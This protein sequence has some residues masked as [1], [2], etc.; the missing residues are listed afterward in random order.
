MNICRQKTISSKNFI[1]NSSRISKYEDY[2]NFRVVILGAEEGHFG[3]VTIKKSSLNASVE[4]AFC[5][6]FSNPEQSNVRLRL[7]QG[8]PTLTVQR[9]AWASARGLRPDGCSGLLMAL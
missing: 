6:L 2:Q 4:G 7:R 3:P 1:K 5:F 9:M 8:I